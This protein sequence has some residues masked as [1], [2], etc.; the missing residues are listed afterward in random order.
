MG[1]Q[2]TQLSDKLTVFF[3]NKKTFLVST[4]SADSKLNSST[5]SMDSLEVFNA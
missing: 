3:H 5:K 2:H 4:T 1:Q